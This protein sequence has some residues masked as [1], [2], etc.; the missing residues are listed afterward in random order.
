[1]RGSP[2][3]ADDEV[4]LRTSTRIRSDM[5]RN[6]E[7]SEIRFEPLQVQALRII[8]RVVATLAMRLLRRASGQNPRG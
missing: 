6:R 3:R 7:K 2:S 1:V 8:G 4:K 5:E